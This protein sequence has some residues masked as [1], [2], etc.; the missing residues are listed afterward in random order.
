MDKKAHCKYMAKMMEG[1]TAYGDFQPVYF[2]NETLLD[3]DVSE[4]PRCDFLLAFYSDNFPLEKAMLYQQLRAPIALNDLALQQVLFDRRLVLALLDACH[5]P[6]PR[7]L[8]A[9]R[10]GGPCVLD[11][12]LCTKLNVFY[13][14]NVSMTRD[15]APCVVK[16]VDEETISVNGQSMRMPF[17]EKPING[18]DHAIRVYYD[19]ARGGGVRRLFRKV[20]D[21][22]SQYYPGYQ[23]IRMD[24]SYIYEE[25][26]DADDAEDVKVYA[27][28]S[29]FAHAEKRKSPVVDGV[30]KHAGTDARS[31]MRRLCR[32]WSK[33]LPTE[34]PRRSGRRCADL[35]FCAG[36]A[37]RR[38]L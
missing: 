22:C 34:S 18:D 29:A 15:E 16:R 27:V 8:V 24:G 9:S 13:G 17:V 19:K 7:R 36:T 11:A 31:D 35:T 30:V 23:D 12:A 25:F 5:V 21:C 1:L 26:I 10:D 20:G 4:W 3:K 33:G 2:G 14:L 28:G 37:A 32:R 38:A 6:T